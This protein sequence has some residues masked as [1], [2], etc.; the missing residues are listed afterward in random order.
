M[1]FRCDQFF[2]GSRWCAAFDPRNRR[3]KR[4]VSYGRRGRLRE[5]SV[6][7]AGRALTVRA[8]VARRTRSRACERSKRS[9]MVKADEMFGR[10]RKCERKLYVPTQ[11]HVS[12]EYSQEE[13]RKENAPYA[14]S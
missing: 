7:R 10:R 14:A 1:S 12:S 9:G 8:R 5:T 13:S 11:E 3:R 6:G 2:G 4:V